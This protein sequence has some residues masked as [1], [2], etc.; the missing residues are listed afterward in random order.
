MGLTSGAVPRAQR[1]WHGIRLAAAAL[2]LF[3]IAADV[4]ADARCHPAVQTPSVTSVSGASSTDDRDP[5]ATGC[6]P[7]CFCCS[8]LSPSHMGPPIQISGPAV[9]VEALAA[10]RFE[11]GVLPLPYR[12][13]LALSL[14]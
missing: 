9:R 10:P 12:P 13:P 6:V 2:V 1:I 7:D 14:S 3:T 11:P 8:T 4:V 5:C